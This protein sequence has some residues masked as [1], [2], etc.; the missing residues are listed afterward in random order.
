MKRVVI[1]LLLSALVFIPSLPA[2]A[3]GDYKIVKHH[4]QRVETGIKARGIYRTSESHPH[5]VV[6][7]FIIQGDH[8]LAEKT[9]RGNGH[10]VRIQLT[11]SCPR[12]AP[13]YAVIQGDTKKGGHFALW[14]SRRIVCTARNR[15]T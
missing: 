2:S 5:L 6:T 11:V 9:N 3:H 15:V 10:R 1:A 8:I 13:V 14:N 12:P 7:V 4:I